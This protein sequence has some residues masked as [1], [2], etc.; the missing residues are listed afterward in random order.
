MQNVSP[1]ALD[2]AVIYSTCG[3]ILVTSGYTG[4]QMVTLCYRWLHW[5][6]SGYTE[7]LVVTLGY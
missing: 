5:V 2:T 6:T 1:Y 4:L 7:I 3:Y